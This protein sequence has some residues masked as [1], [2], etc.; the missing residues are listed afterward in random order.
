MYEV[1]SSESPIYLCIYRC[2]SRDKTEVF[3][4]GEKGNR[5]SQKAVCDQ[6]C[7]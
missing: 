4:R 6:G 7:I 1:S 3:C 2:M 5:V